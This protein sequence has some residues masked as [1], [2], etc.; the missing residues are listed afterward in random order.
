MSSI[1]ISNLKTAGFD[2][3][4]DSESYLKDLNITEQNVQGGIWNAA[5]YALIFLGAAGVGATVSHAWL[6]HEL[7]KDGV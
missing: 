7:W 4:S 5:P 1:E 3:F 2:L 6:E